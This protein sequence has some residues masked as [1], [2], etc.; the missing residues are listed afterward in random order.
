MNDNVRQHF[1][2]DEANFIDVVDEWIREA[3]DQYRP[4]LTH[5]LNPRQVYIAK[6]LINRNDDVHVQFNGGHFNAEMQRALVYPNYYEPV[7]G[8]FN[9]A[10]LNVN[11]PVKFAELHHSTILGTLLGEGGTDRNVLGDILTDGETWQII[12]EA[13]MADYFESQITHVGKVKVRLEPVGLDQVVT[14]INE[15]EPESVFLTSL[16]LDTIVGSGFHLSR[17]RSKELIEAGRIRVNWG[18]ID[19]PDYELAVADI[20]SVRG[21]G[22]IRLDSI[23]GQTKKDKLRVTLSI[24]KK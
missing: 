15:W 9:L 3:E 23:D 13:G 14:P 5:F 12:T 24:L 16:R 19:K 10:A 2:S 6:T 4:V 17:H 20:I 18:E 7:L 1:R 8:D 21:F 11:Y 22:R